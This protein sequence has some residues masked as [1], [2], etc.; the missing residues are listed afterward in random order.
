MTK[1]SSILTRRNITLPTNVCLV[2]DMVFPIVM[3]RCESWTIKKCE[4]WRIDAFKLWCWRWLLRVTL[5]CKEIKPVN[6]KGNQHWIF[7]G[8]KNCEAK[9][10]IAW[11]PDMKSWLTGKDPDAGNDWRHMENGTTEDK[12]VGWHHRFSGHEFEQTP[13]ESEG[14]RSL[15]CCRVALS[16]TQLSNWKQHEDT[17]SLVKTWQDHR[18]K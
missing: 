13:G 15:A 18:Q 16:W 17:I 2:K 14:Q 10:P 5:D 7:I 4:C 6:T 11:P 12:M 9:A 3:Y 8:R 1:L